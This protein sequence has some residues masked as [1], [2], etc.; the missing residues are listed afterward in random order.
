MF[1]DVNYDDFYQ[2]LCIFSTNT[3]VEV[4]SEF[5]HKHNVEKNLKAIVEKFKNNDKYEVN[6]YFYNDNLGIDNAI[7]VTN[8]TTGFYFVYFAR[9]NYD[10]YH[11]YQTLKRA[12][13]AKKD[14][15]YSSSR[16]FNW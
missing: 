11:A 2:I 12:C 4:P 8:K 7:K 14:V 9:H 1:R 13:Y 16:E 5:M 3:K 6:E 10:A 15:A